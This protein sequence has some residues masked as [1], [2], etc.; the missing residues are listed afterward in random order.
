MSN[1]TV[2]GEPNALGFVEVEWG[3]PEAGWVSHAWVRIPANRRRSCL[4]GMIEGERWTAPLETEAS[5]CLVCVRR[6]RGLIDLR[7]RVESALCSK[8]PWPVPRSDL[9]SR[10]P[11][12]RH[13]V[14][15]GIVLGSAVEAGLVGEI[16]IGTGDRRAYYQRTP[17]R[18]AHGVPPIS[19]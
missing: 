16:K 18:L 2:R 5:R 14:V 19:M 9:R 8:Y 11:V 17:L 10:F 6:A 12:L 15:I 13:E 7:S 3:A 4:C 1:A